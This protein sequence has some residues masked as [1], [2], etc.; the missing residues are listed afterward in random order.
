[1]LVRQPVL[2]GVTRMPLHRL[3]KAA[4]MGRGFISAARLK[5][6]GRENRVNLGGVF[7]AAVVVAPDLFGSYRVM[8]EVIG[9]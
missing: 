4:V 7:S 1:M 5:A 9:I 8:S 6:A 2:G 3:V